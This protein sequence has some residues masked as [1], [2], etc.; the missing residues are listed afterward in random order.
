MK[1]IMFV[2]FIFL[3][4]EFCFCTPALFNP[5]VLREGD[6]IFHESSTEQA[7]ALKLATK[8]RYTHVAIILKLNDQWYVEEAVQPVKYTKLES[9]IK[10]GKNNHYVIKRLKDD[11]KLLTPDKIAELKISGKKYLNKNYDICFEWSDKNIY[12]TELV[13]KMYKEVLN[14]EV[15]KL[16]KL[17]DFDLSDNFVKK[18]MKQRYGK[19]IPFDEKVI[20]PKA[21]FESE[22]LETVVVNN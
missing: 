11:G 21:M 2:M 15:G 6:I 10:R 16:E 3:Y 9:F 1:K 7:K 20:S 4:G 14:V 12:C 17:K 13:W 19:N 5:S 22:L 8:S 18:I